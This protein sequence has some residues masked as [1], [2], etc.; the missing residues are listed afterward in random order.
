ML[1]GGLGQ[2]TSYQYP[3]TN[4]SHLLSSPSP[5]PSLPS[6]SHLHSSSCPLTP[7]P[8]PASLTVGLEF[9]LPPHLHPSSHP[10]NQSHVPHQPPL[11][12]Q[13]LQQPC[14]TKCCVW[15]MPTQSSAWLHLSGFILLPDNS[16][17]CYPLNF[18]TEITSAPVPGLDTVNTIQCGGKIC[19]GS[20]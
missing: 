2:A 19:L 13:H 9:R 20:R 3:V 6:L 18:H 7:L 11:I 1:L 14:Q 16:R 10:P 12:S 4:P 8:P 15:S 17:Q 5:P